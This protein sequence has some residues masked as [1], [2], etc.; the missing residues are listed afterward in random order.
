MELKVFLS[1]R[2]ESSEVNLY[3]YELFAK[4]AQVQF[5]IDP[6]SMK[7]MVDGKEQTIRL[8][9]SVTRLERMIRDA[10]AFIG[11]YPYEGDPKNKASDTELR[12]ASRYFRLECEL[13]IRSGKPSIVFLDRRYS[14]CFDLPPPMRLETFDIQEVTGKGGKP[15][16]RGF[17]RVFNDFCKEVTAS[18]AASASQPRRFKEMHVGIVVPTDGPAARRYNSK[19]I[20]SIKDTLVKH[21]ITSITQFPWPPNLHESY[22]TRIE[23]LDFLVLDVGE[24]T[25][26]SGIVGY[27]HG[28]FIPTIRLIKS[29]SSREEVHKQKAYRPLFGGIE[30]GYPKDI[31]IWNDSDILTNE[32]DQRLMVVRVPVERINTKTEAAAYFRKASLRKEAV[33]L[34]YS[35][36]DREVASRISRELKKRFQ[37]VF[38]YKDGESITPGEPWLKEIFDKLS[39]ARFGVPLV[40]SN[41]F[42]SGNC[43]HEALEMV[44]KRD[45][46]EMSIIPI[47]LN[48]DDTFELPTW[49]RNRQYMHYYDYP[50]V[51]TTVDK[52][53]EF[54]DRSRTKA[55]S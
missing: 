31:V 19:D 46:G 47:K 29:R 44:A 48:A 52:L 6:G 42:A 20:A 14:P 10:H 18:M 43:E 15:S 8:P 34:S 2:Y 4:S 11:I 45:A 53:I 9:L 39:V 17:R 1:H 5:E 13:A 23:A 35:G 21:G 33:F 37:Q 54:F 30:V 3:F 22:L 41:Y 55:D 36:R 26:S 38:D 51:E 27:L 50:D 32:L 7:V 49:M 24:Q 12:K 16:S 40:S 25:M 28:R